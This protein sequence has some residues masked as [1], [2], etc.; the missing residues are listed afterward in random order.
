MKEALTVL[1]KEHRENF[2]TNLFYFNFAPFEKDRIFEEIEF[3]KK[4]ESPIYKQSVSAYTWD[5]VILGLE[6]QL[7]ESK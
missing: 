3:L 5:G 1:K 6:V 2:K 7:D 4:C